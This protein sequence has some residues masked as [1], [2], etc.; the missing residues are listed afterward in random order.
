MDFKK[1]FVLFFLLMIFLWMKISAQTWIVPDEAKTKVSPFN[2]TNE[3]TEKGQGLYIKNCQ[4]CHGIPG[5]NNPA[6]IVPDP[7]DPAAV[8]YQ[9]QK[10][11]E[12]FW[13]ITNGKAP[14]PQFQNIL[15]E[16]ERWN[17][18][19]FVRSFNPK[20]VQ[21]Q[22]E[23]R[24]GFTGKIIKL[25]MNYIPDKKKIKV[26]ALEVTKDNKLITSQG[27]GI[28]L[29]VKRYFGNMQL[30]D[31]KITNQ[32]GVALFDAPIDLTGDKEGKI[33]FTARVNDPS[34]KVGDAFVNAIFAIGRPNNVPSLI[35]SRAW[36]STREMAPVWVIATF[37]FAVIIVWGFIFYILLSLRK[38]RKINL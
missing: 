2:F 36:W 21:P 9:T 20:Y 24:A 34:G 16:E 38:I 28:I 37:S 14:M 23:T 32:S 11:G 4:S 3:T 22:P 25:S 7:G 31:T 17:V 12:M 10:D 13:K 30:G 29:S 19:S 15:T 27:I 8:K 18:I 1:Y 35:A 33:E 5:Q 26:I 6:K